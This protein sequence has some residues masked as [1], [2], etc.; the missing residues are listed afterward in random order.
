MTR[1]FLLWLFIVFSS[2]SAFAQ[3]L[4]FSTQVGGEK[5]GIKDQLQVD[6]VLQ[7]A[8]QIESLSP[9]NYTDFNIVGG[10]YQSSQS[11]I[12]MMGNRMVESKTITI[13]YVLQPK[14][15]GTCTVLG[16]IAKDAANH[17]YVSNAVSVQ[18]VN[19]SLAQQKSSSRDPFGDDDQDPWAMMRQQ[20]QQMQQL[21]SGRG[22]QQAPPSNQPAEE[23]KAPADL[24]KDVFIKV[25]VDKS[26]AYVGEQITTSYKLYTRLPMQMSISKLPS[27]NGFWTQDFELPK[28]MKPTEEII[29]GK[30]YQVFL[31]KKS[32]LFPQQVGKLQLDPAEAKGLVRVVQKTKRANPFADDPFFSQFGSLF[33]G[34]PFFDNDLFSGMAYKDIPVTIASA[35]V[36]I[37]VKE[38]PNTKK[39]ITYTGAVG[40]FQ[41]DVQ[42]DKL[43]CS[44]DDALKLKLLIRGSGNLKLI[45]APV[46]DLPKGLE[47]Y[48]PI[49]IDSITGRTTAIEG[50]KQFEYALLPTSPGDYE[51]VPIAFS[52]FNPATQQYESI[53]SQPIHLHVVLGKQLPAN[54]KDK[55]SQF[56]SYNLSINAQ[57]PFYAFDHVWY[58]MIMLLVGLFLL[59]QLTKHKWQK[60]WS[61]WVDKRNNRSNRVALK[62][63]K[64]AQVFLDQKQIEL[65]YEEVSKAIWLYLSDKL[66]IDLASL[67][68]EAALEKLA[69]RQLEQEIIDNVTAVINDCEMALYA[70]SIAEHKM[71]QTYQ[72]TIAI[73]THIENS[74]K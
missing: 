55:L 3:Q 16:A 19:G 13:S 23:I 45:E 17:T 50:F 32:A 18:V 48:D 21:F 43:S 54:K 41:F 49:V 20:M 4:V 40:K 37:N 59:I 33:M 65:F 6:Y 69:A 26:S 42:L 30:K 64:K 74:K 73:I 24:N 57:N 62:R 1:S 71:Q 52:Y 5:M 68:K 9:P 22:R 67:S 34:D 14:H 53:V 58:W 2:W 25:S 51:I 61:D 66:T 72:D 47:K 46:F 60:M 36:S 44:T 15:L 8:Q 27:L 63:M 12:Q 7:N 38:V 70:P 35:P 11:N 56:H 39:P 10:P 31:L 29:N 28:E